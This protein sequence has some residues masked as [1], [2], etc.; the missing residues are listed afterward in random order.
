MT[1]IHKQYESPD[2]YWRIREFFR[3][4]RAADPRPSVNWDVCDF[5]YWRWHTLE[6]VWERDPQELQYWEHSDGQLAAVLVYGDPGVCHPMADPKTVTADLLHEMLGIAESEF[7]TALDDGRRVLFPWAQKDDALLNSVLEARGYEHGSGGHST[8]YHGWRDLQEAPA[9][10]EIPAGY[11]LSSMGDADEYPSRSLA[12]WRVFHPG[13]PDEGAD[14]TGLWYRNIQRAPLYRRDLDV[15]AIEEKSRDIIAFSTCY[16][17]DV[18]RTGTILLSGAAQ[19]HPE[20]ELERAVVIETLRRL[21]W[22]G[23][24]GCYL[25]WFESDPGNVYESAGFQAKAVSRAWKKLF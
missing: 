2:D 4:L 3:S 18:S 7:V 15:V 11:A 5:D 14:P 23:A 19:P 13:E 12:S 25:S 17:D 20:E 8:A 1:F 22:L 16:F 6:N 21:H 10:S 9:S 24:I